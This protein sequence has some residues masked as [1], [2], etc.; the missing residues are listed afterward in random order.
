MNAERFAANEYREYIIYTEL[1]KVET[2]VRFRKILQELAQQ[3]LEHLEFW[4]EQTSKKS[5]SVNPLEI[6]FLKLVRRFLGLTFTVKFLERTEVDA[7]THYEAYR[8][9]I[10]PKYLPRLEEIIQDE[11]RH[12]DFMIKQIRE[13]RVEFT[14]SIVLGLNDGLVEI[15]GALVGFA[16]AFRNHLTV[17]VA[18]L[19]VGISACLS[20]AASA[21]LQARHEDGKNPKKAALYTGVAY[22][23]V[24]IF[25]VSPFL[26]I[27]SLPLA[28]VVMG[29]VVLAIISALSFFTSIVFER[30][31]SATWRE[32][33]VFSMGV[34]LITFGIGL[35]TRK[36]FGLEV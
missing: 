9:T 8:R 35:F 2:D 10:D 29:L 27:T 4:R 15:T 3:E 19:I 5:Y 24:V 25:L 20:M 14:G 22:L 12:E 18:G 23:I 16:F 7:I 6:F 34:A 13:E 1:S 32:M 21:Y 11:K 26:A 30:S 33:F 36:F 17:A 31:F 28:I